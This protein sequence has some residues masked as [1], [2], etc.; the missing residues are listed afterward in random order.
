MLVFIG[1]RYTMSETILFSFVGAQDPFNKDQ[2]NGPIL[3]LISDGTRKFSQIFL[4]HT[5][6]EMQTM[7]AVNTKK[8]I[9]SKNTKVSTIPLSITD[10]TS[11]EQIF[12]ALREYFSSCR[13]SPK[14]EL[15]AS[16]S[17]G[18][19]AMHACW[20]QL[21]ASREIPAN[22]LYI[23][24]RHVKSGEPFVR[25]IDPCSS[26]FPQITPLL[27]V[28]DIPVVSVNK[29]E[30][31][32]S[33]VG[34]IGESPCFK[35]ALNQAMRFSKTP[36]PY[37]V[38]ILGANGTGKELFAR[39]IH[40]NGTRKSKPFK[41][42]NCAALTESLFES[43]LFGHVKEAFTGATKDKDGLFV[44]ADGGTLFLDEV[45]ELP[46]HLQAK[47]LRAL[48]EKII[49]PVGGEVD[50]K[51]DVRII[52]ATNRDIFAMISEKTFREDLFFRISTLD[53]RL[54]AL[55]ER[56]EDIPQLINHFMNKFNADNSTSKSLSPSALALL[57]SHTWPGNIRELEHTVN[58][59]AVMSTSDTISA[60]SVSFLSAR[61][62]TAQP[63]SDL[64][65]F[66]EGFSIKGYL[67]GLK[68]RIY[69]KALLQAGGK[70]EAAR[71]LGV[72]R[73]TVYEVLKGDAGMVAADN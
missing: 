46:M 36:Y 69:R 21:A 65:E 41:A 70:A 25:V 8:Q 52:T 50:R 26:E 53:M 54:P 64:P 1:G 18:T 40:D 11:H 42:V 17:S 38:L 47:L 68:V 71:L 62:T 44:Q 28:G 59:A 31:A 10:P 3:T 9:S 7:R 55:C 37:P 57:N 43:E 15:F 60:E 30:E 35:S 63:L 67:D 20:L 27:R 51:V 24:D 14:D 19:P 23:R 45:A 56:K 72:E 32:A 29:T 5:E 66:N 33:R 58:R 49:T 13:F 12:K 22:L 48:Q 73:N 39:Y 6:D 4:F 34:L 2:I 61:N 16:I